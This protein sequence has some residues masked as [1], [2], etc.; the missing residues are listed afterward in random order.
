MQ[1]DIHLPQ[2]LLHMLDMGGGIGEQTLPMSKIGAKR[3]HLTGR[4]ETA[5]QQVVLMQLL[6]PL[7]IIDVGLSSWYL[8]DVTGIDEQHLQPS[9]FEDLKQRNPVDTRRFHRYRRD[10]KALQPIRQP[11]KVA[12]KAA[13]GL[14]R[15]VG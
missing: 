9:G 11:V 10:L 14:N 2:G 15:C 7:G 13:E 8:L 4:P 5:A 1:L 6:E 12:G 3:S